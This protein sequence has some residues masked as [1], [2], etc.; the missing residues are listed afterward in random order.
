M[1]D[2]RVCAAQQLTTPRAAA[3]RPL[4]GLDAS[5][6]VLQKHLQQKGALEMG[7]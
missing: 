5:G 6:F 7:T 3:L 2:G 4:L 1:G